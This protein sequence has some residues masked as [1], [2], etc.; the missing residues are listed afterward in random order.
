MGL[1]ELLALLSA[2]SG[3]GVDENP[4]A[5]SAADVLA[6]APAHADYMVHIDLGAV[7][8][9]NYARL[10]RLPENDALAK[11]PRAREE[12]RAVLEQIE[13]GRGMLRGLLGMDPITDLHSAT[14]W[15]SVPDAGEPE[16]LLV[17]RGKLARELLE[18]AASA[19]GVAT[20]KVGGSVAIEPEPGILV[21]ISPRGELLAGTAR[22]VE[23]R[24]KRRWQRKRA[25]AM[26]RYLTP[27]LDSKPAFVVASAPGKRLVRRLTRELAADDDA[28]VR[29]LVTGHRFF[30]L[31]VLHDGLEWAVIAREQRGYE[32]ALR[33]SEGALDL[34]RSLHQSARGAVR[35]A[36][37]A[38]PSHADAEGGIV[39]AITRYEDEILDLVL[40]NTGDGRFEATV[41]KAP[42]A[43]RVHVVA[44]GK[45]LK[46]VL[47]VAALLPLVGGGVAF[48]LL[49]QAEQALPIGVP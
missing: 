27:L 48:Y 15:I 12:L 49:G 2:L 17:V 35:I 46:E 34:M 36:L 33:A 37:A 40:A 39:A 9:N 8:P 11:E 16:L 23:P 14:L 26:A 31:A 22:W 38:L 5:P 29:D 24:L 18:Q 42:R 41:D 6:S 13:G 1:L 4:A 20:R 25:A 7:L 28:L 30:G 10:A 32:R 3:F 47:P 19:A 21:A 43:R 44:R 45:D